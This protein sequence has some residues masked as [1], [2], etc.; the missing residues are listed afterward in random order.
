MNTILTTL[1]HKMAEG[2]SWGRAA[3][4][5]PSPFRKIDEVLAAPGI[6]NLAEFKAGLATLMAEDGQGPAIFVA[7][8][9]L[10]DRFDAFDDLR[11]YLIDLCVLKLLNE[12]EEEA[13]EDAF[14]SPEW[15]KIEDAAADRGTE[16]LNALIY[17]KDC[18]LNVVEPDLEDFLYEFLM[19]DEDEYQEELAIYEPLLKNIPLIEAPLKDLVLAGNAQMDNEMRE[20]FT[21]LMLFFRESEST[22]GKLT[23]ALLE[24]SA[25][26]ELHCALYRLMCGFYV[27]G[28]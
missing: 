11:E 25:E 12:I 1:S 28:I 21:P 3:K 15:L 5:A 17:I 26:P 8:D 23:L 4:N 16:L 13:G 10:I 9:A 14:D 7:A 6:A 18:K 22:P 27:S 2:F 20:L 19:A 24:H